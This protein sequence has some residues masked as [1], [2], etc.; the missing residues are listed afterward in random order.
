MMWEYVSIGMTV[1]WYLF[2]VKIYA[3][4]DVVTANK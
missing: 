2:F 1:F 4:A 3:A